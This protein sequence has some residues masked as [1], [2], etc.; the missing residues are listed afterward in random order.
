M[1]KNYS[2]E[3]TPP[4]AIRR[5]ERACDDEWI[6]NYLQSAQIGHIATLWDDQPF[7]K[8]TNFWYDPAQRSLYFH[9]SLTGRLQANVQRNPRACFE[10]S[11]AGRLLPSNLAGGFSIQYASVVAFGIIHLVEDPE[12]RTRAL[13]GL[14]AKYFPGMQ[15]GREYRPIT[16]QELARTAVYE[17]KI[18]SW[19]GKQNWPDQAGQGQDWPP[20][21]VA[22]LSLE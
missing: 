3:I 7:I 6:N 2:L 17:F 9:S 15:P 13:Y 20:L 4:N 16:E 14:I 21:G 12:Q 5:Q 22:W 8:P 11:H 19:S 1:T 18:E 10:A